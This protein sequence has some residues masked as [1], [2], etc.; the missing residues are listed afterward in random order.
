MKK[1]TIVELINGNTLESW[2]Q[3]F[4]NKKDAE[5][6]FA[7]VLISDFDVTDERCIEDYLNDG[8]FFDDTYFSV[9]IKE[10]ELK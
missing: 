9:I 2:V 8:Y 7:N 10:I 3:A 6:E 1:I 4:N 5:E